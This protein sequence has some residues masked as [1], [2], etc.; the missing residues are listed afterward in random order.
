MYVLIRY[1]HLRQGPQQLRSFFP[2]GGQVEHVRGFIQNIPRPVS[3]SGR[4]ELLRSGSS[5]YTRMA[6]QR[7]VTRAKSRRLGPSAG[8]LAE[9][10]LAY[11]DAALDIISTCAT[12]HKMSRDAD[13]GENMRIRA[14]RALSLSMKKMTRRPAS[15][16]AQH[17]LA[18]RTG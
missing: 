18:T 9:A 10:T 2:N 17:F 14:N 1:T 7:C 5:G 15:L 11:H 8:L 16:G 3:Y 6:P 13:T 12:C 4:M